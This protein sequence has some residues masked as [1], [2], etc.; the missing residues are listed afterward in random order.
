MID[1]KKEN[2]NVL[3]LKMQYNITDC[4]F[5]ILSNNLDQYLCVVRRNKENM[6]SIRY[7]T[8]RDLIDYDLDN[9]MIQRFLL[10]FKVYK[11]KL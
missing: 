7:Y 2:K 3:E 5:M 11:Y 6:L 8:V 1:A 9:I 4:I 10:P